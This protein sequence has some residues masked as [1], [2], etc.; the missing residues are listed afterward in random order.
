MYK[1]YGF[2]L[3]ELIAVMVI[4]SILAVTAS[5]LLM[6]HGDEH[7][8]VCRELSVS[9]RSLQNL[10]L[11]EG[12]KPQLFFKIINSSNGDLHFGICKNT[13]ST[14]T[15]AA[16]D[17]TSWLFFASND[18]VKLN[19]TSNEKI[20]FQFDS[21]GRLRNYEGNYYGSDLNVKISSAGG[22]CTV[23]LNKEG[24]ILWH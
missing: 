3:M 23:L 2:T 14:C 15:S 17:Y 12:V 7:I 19:N 18:R 13:N 24:G 1:R 21:M 4:L 5:A 11:N 22:T 20:I 8:Q 6:T 9:I 10:N 16:D